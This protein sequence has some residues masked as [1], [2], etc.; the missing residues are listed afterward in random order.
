MLVAGMDPSSRTH[1]NTPA[2][3]SQAARSAQGLP[4]GHGHAGSCLSGGDTTLTH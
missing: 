4:E 2:G 1:T 3:S